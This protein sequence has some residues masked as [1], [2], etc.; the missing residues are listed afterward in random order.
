MN[1]FNDFLAW[2]ASMFHALTGRLTQFWKVQ[3]RPLLRVLGACIWSV[4][5]LLVGAG[6]MLLSGQ[7]QEIALRTGS[8]AWFAL[9]SLVGLILWAVHNWFGARRILELLEFDKSHVWAR[10]LPR[11]LGSGVALVGLVAFSRA[12]LKGG[13][14]L[15]LLLALLSLVLIF[16]LY[17]LAEARERWGE[18]RHRMRG[19][20]M[21]Q[22]V[23][24]WA[25]EDL[26]WLSARLNPFT[27]LYGAL[28][29]L[30]STAAPVPL[31]FVFGSVGI[32]FLA[33][34]SI[35]WA[36]SWLSLKMAGA[37]PRELVMGPP[38]VRRAGAL[39]VLVALAWEQPFK[40]LAV[41]ALAWLVWRFRKTPWMNRL[42]DLLQLLLG[43][44]RHQWS[45]LIG[46]LYR[47]KAL[48]DPVAEPQPATNKKIDPDCPR[49]LG[50]FPV[51]STLALMALLFSATGLNDNHAFPVQP[52]PAQRPTVA[53]YN[54]T[55]FE[56]APATGAD[57][58]KPLIIVA[59]A[60]G[61]IRAAYWTAS[62]LGG[63]TDA[64]PAFRQS[65]YAISGVSGGS[66][67]AAVY[68]SS[69]EA[70]GAAC[71]TSN[72]P[73]C[74]RD[75]MRQ[76]LSGEFLAPTVARMLYPDLAQRFL[77]IALLPDR[78]SVLESAWQS[79]WRTSFKDHPGDGLEASFSRLAGVGQ[80]GWQPA[81]LLNSTHVETGKRVI[82]SSL[83]LGSAPNQFLDAVDL[84]ELTKQDLRLGTA[85]LNSARFTYV[86]PPG[87]LP[88]EGLPLLRRCNGHV[89]DGGYYENFGAV[90]ALQTLKAAEQNWGGADFRAKV[91][92]IVIL[93]SNDVSLVRNAEGQEYRVIE[94]NRQPGR[95][96]RDSIA[97]ESLGPLLA[98]AHTRDARG[99]AAA[100]TLWQAVDPADRYHFSMDLKPGDPEPALG[101]VLARQSETLMC[102][103][104]TSS[105]HNQGEMQR[106]LL[107][108]GMTM[109][110]VQAV[111]DPA[112]SGCQ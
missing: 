26:D 21:G 44:A 98:L 76:A 2:L 105:P 69:L 107:S 66:V 72:A 48:P 20:R 10:R 18:Q 56:Q 31:G 65:L 19:S 50:Y 43:F 60:G 89:V 94:E 11:L 55:W 9:A 111:T 23:A 97:M 51:L 68:A 35:V 14:T 24:N 30:L 108:L 61:G 5:V 29:F 39:M 103:L 79:V 104:L 71:A 37:E 58:R 109:E 95:L 80:R 1:A 38:W 63:L 40:F 64:Q 34:S 93:I 86:S 83:V 74:L 12:W 15:L 59:T 101:W 45:G 33:L 102:R 16:A 88:C 70:A 91:R 7:G 47:L 87:T 90:T 54:R 36:G 85:A 62:V 84:I 75:L 57:G 78:A 6:L 99:I 3:A 8:N 49:D 77:P 73:H 67:G 42:I 4:L 22:L 13:D 110:Q 32:V 82:A 41:I 100:K 96:P 52:D 92:P 27:L 28:L 81:L 46:L 112:Q 106:L 17:R 53:D 25:F